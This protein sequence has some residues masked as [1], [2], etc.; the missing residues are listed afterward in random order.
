[1]R[2]RKPKPAAL[3]IA[4]GDPR[5]RGARKLK[6]H[7]EAEPKAASGLPQCPAHLEGVARDVWEFLVAELESME[8]DKRPDALMLEGCCVNYARAVK[9]DA[10]VNRDGITVEESIIDDDTGD[11]VVT[12][13]KKNPAVDV[14][15]RAWAMV[16][17]FCSDFGLSPVSRTRLAIKKDESSTEDLMELLS[18]P[19]ECRDSTV[20]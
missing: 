18:Q 10:A 8:M 17:R 19:Y 14:S 4:E 16:H 7:L 6:E 1:M 11:R 12:K 20:N 5:K 15:N 3:Q 13:I 2:G 9:A